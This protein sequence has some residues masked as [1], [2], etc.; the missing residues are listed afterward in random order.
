MTCE[1]LLVVGM[2]TAALW[3][4]LYQTAAMVTADTYMMMLQLSQSRLYYDVYLQ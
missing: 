1:M 3:K 2:T 4:T